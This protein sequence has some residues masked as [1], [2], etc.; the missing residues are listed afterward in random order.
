MY[1]AHEHYARPAPDAAPSDLIL[2]GGAS[3]A[4]T[5]L[6]RLAEEVRT[7]GLPPGGLSIRCFDKNGLA[8]GGIAYG[9]CSDHHILNS[10]RT[11]MSPWKVDAFHDFCVEKGLGSCRNEFNKRKDYAEFLKGAVDNA[12]SSLLQA[13]VQISVDHRNVSIE[14]AAGDRFNI[15]DI[16]GGHSLLSN[17]TARQIALAVGYGPNNNFQNL[18]GEKGYIHSLYGSGAQQIAHIKD[19]AQ[20]TFIGRGPALYDFTNDLKGAGITNVRLNVVSRSGNGALGVRDVSIEASETSS[21]PH[22]LTNGSCGCVEDLKKGMSQAYETASSPRRAALDVLR[23]YG[24]VVTSLDADE[25]R[26][27]YRSPI[28]DVLRHAATPVPLSSH[29]TLS[30]FNPVFVQAEVGGGD[31]TVKKDGFDIDAG[32][33]RIIHA[34]YIVNGTG[35]GRHSSPIIEQLKDDGLARVSPVLGVLE[36]DESGYRLAGSGIACIGPA[37]HAG[38]DGVESFDVYAKSFVEDLW[39]HAGR[40]PQIT[41]PAQEHRLQA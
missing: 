6:I 29:V 15:R 39:A 1:A 24:P 40:N 35:H 23:H 10:V 30:S 8:N 33:G 4:S 41:R 7:R 19:G 13:G 26:D 31:I 27:F 36:T 18:R 5:V 16:D 9:G 21:V 11:E 12:V 17:C 25:A 14:K 3:S 38:C 28:M 34:D 37:I 2:I 32:Q 22:F 20:I